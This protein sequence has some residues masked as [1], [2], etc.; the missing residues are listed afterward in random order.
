MALP[1][2]TQAPVQ[3]GVNFLSY[4]LYVSGGGLP[5][6]N[7]WWEDCSLV[8]HNGFNPQ[9]PQQTKLGVMIKLHD[10]QDL[11]GDV[12][13]VFYGLG[14]K[15]HLSFAPD[16]TGKKLVPIPGA[17]ACQFYDSTN[18]AVLLKSLI[19]CDPVIQTLATNDLSVF[20][21]IWAHMEPV[22]EPESR[23]GFSQGATTGEATLE[24][25]KDQT[26]PVVTNI[27]DNGKPWEGTGGRPK[28]SITVTAPKVNGAPAVV[29]APAA[30][31]DD[32]LKSAAIS[33]LSVVLEKKPEGCTKLL[34]RVN[35][36]KSITDTY[37]AEISTAVTAQYFD[38]EAAF[39]AVL[40]ELGYTLSGGTIKPL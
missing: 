38:D 19:D 39:S 35:A 40:G 28:G 18:F 20:D 7:Y 36:I 33:G 31:T 16:P 14:T 11:K 23:K 24:P 3:D 30:S 21:G 25:R 4:G 34:G 32:D 5:A 10:L 6:G 15:A 37:G 17:P 27:L 22:P 26:I 8:L 13:P 29:A 9:K 1:K 12:K 2:K